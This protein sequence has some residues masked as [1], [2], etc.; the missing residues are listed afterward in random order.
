MQNEW[1]L[2]IA[3]IAIG[4]AGTWF[5]GRL[6]QPL[7]AYVRMTTAVLLCALIWLVPNESSI[8]PKLILTLLA[9]YALY[10]GIM[11]IQKHKNSL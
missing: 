7:Q 6:R 10:R 11:V 4:V 9:G 3:A 5:I 8:W 1:I 2:I